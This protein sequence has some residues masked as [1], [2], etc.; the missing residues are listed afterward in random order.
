MLDE[1]GLDT[2]SV[3]MADLIADAG[4]GVRMHPPILKCV[5]CFFNRDIGSAGTR[6][7]ILT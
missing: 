7:T 1:R 3:E 6:T 4:N 5:Q 2:S